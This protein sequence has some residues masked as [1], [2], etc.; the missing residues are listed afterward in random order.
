MF[1]AV[2]LCVG[3]YVTTYSYPFVF[4]VAVTVCGRAPENQYTTQRLVV[5]TAFCCVRS[6]VLDIFYI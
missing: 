4:Y 5:F 3:R 2:L 6:G 1:S